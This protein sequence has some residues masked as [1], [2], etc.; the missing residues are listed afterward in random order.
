MD[1]H[2]IQRGLGELE[3]PSGA[4]GAAHGPMAGAA[5]TVVLSLHTC[6]RSIP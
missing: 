3:K 1:P 2:R 4:V 6:A 5:P